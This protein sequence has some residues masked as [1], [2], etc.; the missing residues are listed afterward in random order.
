MEVNEEMD[1]DEEELD[2]ELLVPE[3]QFNEADGEVNLDLRRVSEIV[4]ALAYFGK[5]LGWAGI[6]QVHMAPISGQSGPQ[7]RICG[8]FV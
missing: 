8:Q 7:E 1:D 6:G 4:L 2:L 5:D 3:V